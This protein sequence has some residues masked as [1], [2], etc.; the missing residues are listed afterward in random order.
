[1]PRGR[2]A[3]VSNKLDQYLA[4]A[5]RERTTKAYASAI[6]HFEVDWGGMLPAS[7]E[8]VARYLADHAESLTANTLRQRLA[9]LGHWH[10]AHGFV[11]PTRMPIVK[12]ALRGIRVVHARVE[13]QATPLQLT[14]LGRVA[15]WQGEAI[16][17]AQA[18]HDRPGELRALRDR[19]LILLGFWRGFRSDELIH[20]RVEHIT[21]EPG[22]MKCFLRRTKTDTGKTY[23]VPALTRWCAVDA[24]REWLRVSGLTE[25]P[26]LP[27]VGP[28][29]QF[30][31]KHL[32]ANSVIRMLRS[33]M[34][35]AGLPAQL[36]SS[37][38]LRRGFASWAT[39]NGWD[40]KSLMAY[41]GWRDPASAMRYID[42][43]DRFDL[44]ASESSA[45]SV[46]LIAPEPPSTAK[47]EIVL[48]LHLRALRPGGRGARQA[49]R[50]IEQNYLSPFAAHRLDA[51]GTNYRLMMSADE[52]EREEDIAQ[53]LD[54][55]YRVAGD[56]DSEIEA[57]LTDPSSGQHWE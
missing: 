30:G 37:H 6:R 55:I 45:T 19:A 52:L 10:S 39:R 16:A 12:Q 1:M 8:G 11:D 26:L 24:V 18:N 46:A 15:E 28:Q 57:V 50:V 48:E 20:L 43:T 32:H 17:H 3:G 54:S 4:A 35:R 40:L 5:Q 2:V 27:K 14:D 7:G 56:H 13:R 31:T 29:G 44:P 41:V 38:S 51:K 42:T 36:Y 25:G 34:A 33:A 49:H 21:F 23:K 53:L 22:G 47:R 9:A